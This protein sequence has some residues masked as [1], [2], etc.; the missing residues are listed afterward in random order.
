LIPI[1][2]YLGRR[3]EVAD[4]LAR[5]REAPRSEP[6]LESLA[7]AHVI[8]GDGQAAAREAR[9][10][11][12]SALLAAE[13]IGPGEE[14]A[15]RAR[16]DLPGRWL[17]LYG[18]HREA[19]ERLTAF[20]A[21]AR[22]GDP[23]ASQTRALIGSSRLAA[24]VGAREL[25]SELA[26]RAVA[27][28]PGPGPTFAIELAYR[29]E[30][31]LAEGV[32]RKLTPG[33]PRERAYRAVVSWRRGD[34]ESARALLE[35]LCRTS[36]FLHSAP[37]PLFLRAQLLAEMGRDAEAVDALEAFRSNF[38]IWEH[39]RQENYPKAL[40]LL[41][42]LHERLGNRARAGK[43]VADLLHLWRQADPDLPPLVEAKALM[44]R[45]DA[46]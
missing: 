1:L 9:V 31:E 7:W 6:V 35:E 5:L 19:K 34:R 11:I 21:K 4:L 16:P 20:Q 43:A 25:A 22:A 3:A 37:S 24:A 27:A 17:L 32:A 13:G 42:R 44:A 33:S 38:G 28:E 8:L 15:F 30:L 39:D 2:G 41:A 10:P 29:G 14:D 46:R 40:L 36:P 18:R 45:L 23:G 12:F 26:R